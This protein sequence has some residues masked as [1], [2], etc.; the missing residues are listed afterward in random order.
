MRCSG[1][2]LCTPSILRV[3]IEVCHA[4]ESWHL[5]IRQEKPGCQPRWHD[6]QNDA[7]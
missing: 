6:N 5:E 3:L 7:F 4:S 1:L 2:H